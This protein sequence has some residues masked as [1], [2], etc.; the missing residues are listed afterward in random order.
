M[1][2]HT[3]SA[4]TSLS[5]ASG[6]GAL[7]G[8][9]RGPPNKSNVAPL[10]SLEW[11][12]GPVLARSVPTPPEI[13]AACTE[14]TP[15]IEIVPLE[16][17]VEGGVGGIRICPSMMQPG[18]DEKVAKRLAALLAPATPTTAKL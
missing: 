12:G 17:G 1:H 4:E 6:E 10:L 7:A 3:L 16:P 2:I 9:G 5:G 13:V 18:D 11:E 14:G 8:H 15:R